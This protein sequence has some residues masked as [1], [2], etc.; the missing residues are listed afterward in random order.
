MDKECSMNGDD[1]KCRKYCETMYKTCVCLC[2]HFQLCK[3][4]LLHS[5]LVK[6]TEMESITFPVK[7]S[8]LQS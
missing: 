2:V 1:E 5:F 4:Y 7:S 8:V 6:A 3:I